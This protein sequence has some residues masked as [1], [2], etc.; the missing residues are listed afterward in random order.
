MQLALLEVPSQ[1]GFSSCFMPLAHQWCRLQLP[2]PKA[3]EA[4][5]AVASVDDVVPD[6]VA[7]GLT[8]AP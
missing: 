8:S 1:R 7:A 2:S 3:A 6:V 5:A 4:L